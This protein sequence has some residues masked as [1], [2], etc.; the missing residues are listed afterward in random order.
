ML[1]MA[2][3]SGT[4]V[5]GNSVSRC[6]MRIATRLLRQRENLSGRRPPKLGCITPQIPN[7]HAGASWEPAGSLPISAAVS[8][9]RA[10]S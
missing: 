7:V 3:L 1:S 6:R 4:S 9:Q 2:E 10:M 5:D 8:P